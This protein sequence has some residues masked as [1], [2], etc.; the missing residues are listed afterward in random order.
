MSLSKSFKKRL[1]RFCLGRLKRLVADGRMRPFTVDEE[2]VW[3]KTGYDFWI[4][5]DLRTKILKLESNPVWEKAISRLIWDS[6]QDKV[7][8]DIGANI[9][10]FSLLAA[11]AGAKAVYAFE[12]VPYTY[13]LLQKNIFK[14]HLE[15]CIRSYN[16]AVGS[17]EKTLSFTVDLGPKNHAEYLCGSER[18]PR[19]ARRKVPVPVWTLDEFVRREA[20]REIGILKTDTEGYDF[21]VLLGA[22][23]TLLQFRPMLIVEVNDFWLQKYHASKMM[24]L[25]KLHSL[26]YRQIADSV[27]IPV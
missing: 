18:R 14:N 4:Y 1:N 10:Y 9:G 20:L 2:G 6:V 12:P 22:E 26:N 15:G 19:K 24:L 16:C 27:F 25:D 7:F 3:Y 23:K 13:A 21:N 11:R 8:V 5:S 17:Q